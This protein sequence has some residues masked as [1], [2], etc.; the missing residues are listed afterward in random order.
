MSNT[1]QSGTICKKSGKFYVRY[2]KG[3]GTRPYVFICTA[4]PKAPGYLD[5]HEREKRKS[6]ILDSLAVNENTISEETKQGITFKVAASS[7]LNNGINRKRDP[8]APVTSAGYHSILNNLNPLIGEIPLAQITNGKVKETLE[9]IA[10]KT[11]KSGKAFSGTTVEHHFKVIKLVIASIM[12]GE[13]EEV[14]PR[15]WKY[16]FIFENIAKGK[17]SQPCFSA[18]QVAAIVAAAKGHYAVMYALQAA[19]GMR[20][21]ELLAIKVDPYSEDHTTISA[22]CKT[23]FVRKSVYKGK[24]GLLKTEAAY[25]DIDLCGEISEYVQKFIGKRTTGFLFCTKS[26]KPMS[27]RNVLRDSLH[28]ILYGQE[29]KNRFGKVVKTIP[30]VAPQM[31][32]K[33]CASHAF[34]RYRVTH[35]RMMATPE[36]ILKFWAG[37]AE[38]NI[39]DKYSKMKENIENRQH[40]ADL[41]GIGF[42]IPAQVEADTETQP[43]I[44]QETAA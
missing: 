19:T 33:G 37:H 20:F 34:R 21:S 16:N 2:Y 25:R 28:K 12:D 4:D 32:G 9:A 26:G 15:K 6:Q 3:D 24:E 14:Y 36:D 11:T 30:G 23:V 17:P 13:G 35:L 5:K 29:I 31:K 1:I 40:W 38:Q 22:D 43:Q 7:W 39:T 41:V 10:E 18:S 8:F 42:E 44:E 27:Q